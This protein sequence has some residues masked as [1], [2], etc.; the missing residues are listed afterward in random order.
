[1]LMFALPHPAVAGRVLYQQCFTSRGNPTDGIKATLLAGGLFYS[2]SGYRVNETVA[3]RFNQCDRTTIIFDGADAL[4]QN[5][6]TV[7]P[8]PNNVTIPLNGH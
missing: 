2:W 7:N 4:R 6:I 8:L 5:A 3:N 1:M